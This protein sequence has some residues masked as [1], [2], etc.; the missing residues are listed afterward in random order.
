MVLV[1]FEKRFILLKTMK[2]ASTS[3][4][5]LVAAALGHGVLNQEVQPEVVEE[6]CY[7]SGRKRHGPVN[8]KE[9]L[10]GHSTLHEVLRKFPQA[11]DFQV[12]TVV[13]NPYSRYLSYF[14]WRLKRNPDLW[15]LLKNSPASIQKAVVS[16]WIRTR[17]PPARFF[18]S[19]LVF[20]K[21]MEEI[22]VIRFEDYQSDLARFASKVDLNIDQVVLPELKTGVSPRPQR[23]VRDYFSAP[24]K[25]LVIADANIEFKSFCY[26]E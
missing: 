5:S 25:R 12:W 18:V 11:A 13:R 22:Q 7:I 1:C 24:A 2:A 14:W 17:K 26:A 15:G 19:H 10:G 16:H 4:E 9:I 6:C 21:K 8:L 23:D 20:P 3:I